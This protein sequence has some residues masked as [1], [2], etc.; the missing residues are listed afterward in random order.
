MKNPEEKLFNAITQIDDDLIA[1]AE[2]KTSGTR[3]NT[4]KSLLAFAACFVVFVA[5]CVPLSSV[6]SKY[7]SKTADGNAE[8]PETYSS[9]DEAADKQEPVRGNSSFNS[10]EMDAA[11]NKGDFEDD[12]N[13]VTSTKQNPYFNAT[14]IEVRDKAVLV[15]PVPTEGGQELGGEI[16]ISLDVVSTIP[17]PEMKKGD[18]IRVVYNGMIEETMP[19]K[20]PT[21][22][23]IYA[24]TEDGEVVYPTDHPTQPHD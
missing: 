8:L 10:D 21:A 22:F 23:A 17:L 24:V 13:A 15:K 2:G 7:G 5:L 3:K 1:E 19:M 11:T 6:F 4:L 20:I 9:A 14:I 12:K 16:E 18:T